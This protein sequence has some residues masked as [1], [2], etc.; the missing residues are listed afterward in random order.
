MSDGWTEAT[1]GDVTT[2]LV[3]RYLPKEEYAGGGPYPIYGSNSLMG[4]GPKALYLGPMV[5][6][7][8]IGAYAGAVRLSAGPAWVNNNAFAL[9]PAIDA[10][11]A[12]Y[13]WLWLASRLDLDAVRAGT[14]QPYVKRDALRIQPI[15]YPPLDEQRRIVDLIGAVDDAERM[16]TRVAHVQRQ[17]RQAML[18]DLL[19]GS[20]N[21]NGWLVRTLGDVADIRIGRTPPRKEARYWTTDLTRPFCTIA[22][23]DGRVI[24]PQGEGVTEVAVAE[25]K[26]KR[27]PAGSLLLSFKLTIGRVGFAGRDVFPNEAIAWVEPKVESL[28]SGY[29]GLWLGSADLEASTGRAVKGMTL[30]S[31]SLR[32]IPVAIPPLA[33]QQRIVRL[34][35][36]LDATSEATGAYIDALLIFRRAMLSDL[37][38][39]EHAIPVSYDRFLDAAA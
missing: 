14:G 23:M 19:L 33:E 28:L 35:D 12:S 13:L 24:M 10:L 25:G 30:N 37:L 20:A 32:A 2:H 17:T 26:A 29:L 21:G 8:A 5:V 3:G 4:Y 36:G 18:A 1:I 9:I 39:G 7:A 6:M 31:A 16:A 27:V 11:D 34:I 15:R 22:D 38:S